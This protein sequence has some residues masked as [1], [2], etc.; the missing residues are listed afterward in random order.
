MEDAS[1]G[2]SRVWCEQELSELPS[3]VFCKAE[4]VLSKE[5][6]CKEYY[7]PHGVEKI[8]YDNA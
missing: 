6:L 4:A 2:G 5:S 3:Q 1:N 8:K 7:L